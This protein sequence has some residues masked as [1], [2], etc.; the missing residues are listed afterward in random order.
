MQASYQ[1]DEKRNRALIVIGKPKD[2][3]MVMT[4]G[5]AAELIEQLTRA[6]AFA[7]YDF[8]AST[9]NRDAPAKKAAISREERDALDKIHKLA[10]R[11]WRKG[12][13]DGWL[14]VMQIAD[15]KRTYR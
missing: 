8:T 2:P 5:D 4:V 13:S 1:Y 9:P 11:Q 15:P 7:F 12:T 6:I 3:D 14:K 10:V